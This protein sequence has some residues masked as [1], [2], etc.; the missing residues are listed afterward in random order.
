MEQPTIITTESTGLWVSE[1]IA[2]VGSSCR[3]PGGATSPSKLWELLRDPRDV[4]ADISA[5]ERFDI[6]AFYHKDGDHHGTSNVTKSYLLDDDYRVF[7][8]GFFGIHRREA[9]TMDPQQKMLLEVVYEAVEAAGYSMHSLRGTET[10]V[11]VGQMTDDYRDVLFRDID[12]APQY[13]A[14]GV[15]RAILA[16]RVSYFFDWH[17]PSVNIDTACS[18][19]LVALHQAVQA[20]RNRDSTIAITAGSNLILGPEMFIMES[21]LHML[22]P[23]GRCRMWD[24]E[25]DGYG[26]GEG[27]AVVVL[28]TLQQALADNDHIECIIRETGV[29]QDGRSQGLT[30]PSAASQATLIRSTYARCGLDITRAEDRCQYFEAHGTGTTVGD[31]KEAKAIRD[32]F[33]SDNHDT[34]DATDAGLQSETDDK[35][36]YVGSVKTVIGH[37]EG[38]A[39]LVGVLKASLALQNAQIP[40]NMLFKQL[41]PAVAPFYYPRL[42]VPTELRPWPKSA[43][44]A[45]R[46]ASVNSFGFGGTNAHV[47]LESWDG[48]EHGSSSRTEHDDGHPMDLCSAAYG[49]FT[50]SANSKAALIRTVSQL[51]KTLKNSTQN[52]GLAD[53]AEMLQS[54]RTEFPF[55]A[56]LSAANK[57]DLIGNL[58]AFVTEAQGGGVDLHDADKSVLISPEYPLRILAVFT[59]QGAQWPRMGACL[60]EQSP[61]FRNSIQRLEDSLACLPD[62]PP[63]SLVEEL[64]AAESESKV[65]EAEFAQP[66]TT[67]LQIALVDLLRASGVRFSVVV[68]HSSGEIAAAYASGYLS[69]QDAIRVAFYRGLHSALAQSPETGQPGSMMAVGMSLDEATAFCQNSDILSRVA[70]AASN[71]PSSVTLSGDSDAI[72]EAKTILD[73]RGTFTRILQV[74]KAYH[75]HHMKPCADAYLQSLAKCSIQPRR[76]SVD[77]DCAWYSSVHGPDGRSVHDPDALRD[78]YWVEN[79]VKPVLFYQAVGRAAREEDHCLDLALEIGPH[80]ALRGPV[81]DA[82]KVVTGVKI[83]YLSLLARSA[84]E[85][86]TFSDALGAIWMKF[87][88]LPGTAP[89]ID[90]WDHE[91]P[92]FFESPGYVSMAVDAVGILANLLEPRVEQAQAYPIE[93]TDLQFHRAV[94][95]DDDMPGGVDITLIMRVLH[96]NS[97][98][99]TVEAEVSCYSG[100][101]D[102]HPEEAAIKGVGSTALN[103]SGHAVIFLPHEEAAPSSILPIRTAPELPLG[104]V[105][106]ARFYSWVSS[107]GLQYSGDFLVESIQRR[108]N[109]ATVVVKRPDQSSSGVMRIYPPTLDATLHG[110]FAAYSFPG[111]GRMS[112]AYLP[113]RIDRVRIDLGAGSLCDCQHNSDQRNVGRLLADC[114]VRNDSNTA[115]SGDVELFC[116]GCERPEIQIEGAVISRLSPPT[117]QD[118]R[119]LYA[120][121]VWGRDFQSCGFETQNYTAEQR[122]ERAILNEICERTAYF[123]IKQLFNDFRR[124]EIQSM[125]WNFQYLMDWII[126]DVVPTVETG[127]HARVRA[128]WA[129]DTRQDIDIWREKYADHIE[130]KIIHAVGQS[131]PTVMGASSSPAGADQVSVLDSLMKDNLMSQLYHHAEGFW[132]ANQLVGLAVGQLAHRYPHMRILEVGGGTGAATAATMPQL[133][134]HFSSYTFTDISA[135]FFHDTKSI[136][137]N[138]PGFDKMRFATLDMEQ[139]PQEQGFED[140]SFDLVIAS[141]VLHATRSLARSLLHCRRLL[142]PGGFLVLDEVTSDTLWGPFIVSGLPGWWLGRDGDGRIYSPLV[143]EDRWDQILKVNGFSGVDHVVR[144]TPDSSSYLFSIMVS[145]ATDANVDF[146]RA[147]LKAAGPESPSFTDDVSTDSAYKLDNLVIVGAPTGLAAQTALDMNTFLRMVFLDR[148]ECG[149]ILWSNETELAIRNGIL[150]TPR[151]KPHDRLNSRLASGKRVVREDVSVETVASNL[152]VEVDVDQDGTFALREVTV[153]ALSATI[154]GI[155]GESVTRFTSH[156][157]SLFAFET[158]DGADAVHICV[159]HTK[160][161]PNQ[162]FVA[163]SQANSSYF[164]V[165]Y[166]DLMLCEDTSMQHGDMLRHI[167]AIIMCE[168][169]LSNISGSLWL[170][171]APV[172]IAETAR[173]MGESQNVGVFLS[174]SIASRAA[175]SSGAV[176]FLHPRSTLRVLEGMLPSK[177]GR[178]CFMGMDNGDNAQALQDALLRANI[179]AKAQIR[180]WCQDVSSARTVPLDLRSSQFRN[181]IARECSSLYYR[182]FRHEMSSVSGAI[183]LGKLS[184]T[185][186]HNEVTSIID[187]TR[188]TDPVT[189]VPIHSIP[190]QLRPLCYGSRRL[191]KPETTYMLVGLAGGLGMSLVEWMAGMGARHF[192]IISRNPQIDAAVIRHLQRSGVNL[193]TW[194]L[195]VADAQALRSAHS[196][197]LARMPPIAGVANGAM[198]LRDRLFVNM[199]SEDFEAAMRPKALGTKNLDEIFYNDRSL[200]F[201][202]LFASAACVAGNAGQANYS[203]ANMFMASLAEQR[204]RRGLASSVIYL[205]T[206]LGVGHVARIMEEGGAS[207]RTI[208]S[209]LRRTLSLPLSEE[210][211]HTT[212]AEAVA[213]GHPESGMDSDIIVGLGDGSVWITTGSEQRS[214]ICQKNYL[215]STEGKNLF[216][217]NF[218][219]LWSYRIQKQCRC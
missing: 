171:E 54:R 106:T 173:L 138:S 116:A 9:E 62:A 134:G 175:T 10:G 56:A 72:L 139:D 192:A 182:P 11:F 64:L 75:S 95:F 187:W 207:N 143:S 35:I 89:V 74:N 188:A 157:S 124:D 174:T 146:L 209:Q 63:W 125:E 46:R 183:D 189:A 110:V 15:S 203:A 206:L 131:L 22:S 49:P 103:F 17:G 82:L 2:I 177:I 179:V 149:D 80:P 181:T 43:L 172:E 102:A 168:S 51:S 97:A 29:N 210:E 59:G 198:V 24:A 217:I 47:I 42:Q 159:G 37:T 219:Q 108:R 117:S 91:K 85:R 191:F 127:R 156:C 193:Q 178:L 147:P 7:D 107:T 202:V 144:D 1:P 14:T 101:T 185:S 50:L 61:L 170:H 71:S 163:L 200:D 132:Q 204:R 92:L 140:H 186:W 216:A 128:E 151:I 142:R 100:D 78:K 196:D 68:G 88:P 86:V 57:Q 45:P 34:G 40:P 121:T 30:V 20:L 87:Q 160:E 39:G 214:T 41:S 44:G 99:N 126:Q 73:Q 8:H 79:M 137:F 105:D 27:V 94:A 194:A 104:S 215:S 18:S 23:S 60:F 4:L 201:F 213:C 83:P 12:N 13:S 65:H 81:Q 19:S 90:C 115:I 136:F 176:T 21:K 69:A 109:T 31:P 96:R 93:L 218:N 53:V 123:F 141:N 67:A 145:Q 150:F 112:G 98:R 55:R 28:K 199:A 16:N 195:D 180:R 25:A 52:L 162:M 165:S 211:L 130:I 76:T 161:R 155:R 129:A 6:G 205:G 114:Y 120:R 111:D 148:P 133:S 118:D 70:V 164:D 32:A 58:D 169:F 119:V 167:I 152:P 135:A 3:L 66:L 38:A 113:S 190:V 184:A 158:C 122:R 154:D 33:Y 208:E 166:K 36:L 5:A 26:R 77:G 153:D 212:F 197:I 48:S 84:D